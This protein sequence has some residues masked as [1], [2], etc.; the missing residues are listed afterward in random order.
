[1]ALCGDLGDDQPMRRDE[2]EAQASKLNRELGER[3]E[4]N[5]YYVEVETSP[6]AWAVVKRTEPEK[7]RSRLRKFFDA[8][9]ES[10]GAP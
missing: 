1:V 6:G 5:S 8:L 3:G 4:M 9:F 7:E 2:A 10:G